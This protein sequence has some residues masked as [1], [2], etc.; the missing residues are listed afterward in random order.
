MP[1]LDHFTQQKLVELAAKNQRRTLRETTREQGVEVQRGGKKLLSFSCNDYLGLSQHSRVTA[2]AKHAIEAYGAGAGASRLVTGNHPL[3]AILEAKLAAMKHTQAALVFG[4]GYLANIGIIPALVGKG[5]LIL[6]DKLVHA[7]LLDGAKL[8]SAVLKRFAHNDVAQAEKLLTKH[9]KD[10]KHCLILTDSIF[11]MDGDKAPIAALRNLAD[12]HD[13]W[14]L[15]DDAHGLGILARDDNTPKAHVQMGTLSKAVG[16]Y[17]GYVCA[18]QSV[19]DYL[20]TAARSLVFSTA[21]PPMVIAAAYEALCIIDEDL[22][23]REKPLHLA[24]IFTRALNLPE[25][26]SAIVPLIL[27]SEAAALKAS[28]ALEE[29]GFLVSA[30]RPPTVPA[31]TA[32]LRFTFSALHKEQDVVRLAQALLR[33]KVTGFSE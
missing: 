26:E 22:L 23:L 28:A 24:R 15:S 1:T 5:D 6:A 21:L 32:R 13:A 18:S 2:A 11:S 30:I 33:L 20:A 29:E 14:L 16:A 7:C 19:I 12:V 17:G 9:R 10:Y 3:Y 8:S 4:S 31:G 27:G 25:A